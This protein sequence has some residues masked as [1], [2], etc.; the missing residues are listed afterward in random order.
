MS[1]AAAFTEIFVPLKVEGAQHK[2]NAHNNY[3]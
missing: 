3:Y 2:V 1:L